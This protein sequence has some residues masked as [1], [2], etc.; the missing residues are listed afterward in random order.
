MVAVVGLSFIGGI[1]AEP[2]SL[3]GHQAA[4]ADSLPARERPSADRLIVPR[5]TPLVD[6]RDDYDVQHYVLDLWLDLDNQVIGG[7]VTVQSLVVAA[8]L[9]TMVLD[10]LDNM[11]VD[12]V[13]IG[14]A[15]L[16]FT[17]QGD[18]VRIALDRAYLQGEEISPVVFYHGH[19]SYT[20]WATFRFSTHGFPGV[21]LVFSISWPDNSRGWWPCKDVLYDKAT[22]EVR[23]TVPVDQ[24]DMVV[25]SIGRLISVVQNPDTTRTYTWRESYPITTYNISFSTTNFDT[26]QDR[27]VGLDGDTLSVVHFV[28]PEDRER[29]RESFSN[30]VN[31]MEVYAG[32]YGEYPFMGEKYGMAEV[33]LSGAMEHQTMTSYGKMLITGGHTYDTIV[34]HELSHQW[35]GD[36]ITIGTWP[37]IWLS[38]GFATYSE[39]LYEESLY[40]LQGYLDYMESLDTHDFNDTVYDP[41]NLLS[42]TVYN[43]GAW[44][45]HM[46]RHVMGDSLLFETLSDYAADTTFRYGNAV[47]ADFISACEDHYGGDLDWFFTPWLNTV[48]RPYYYMDWSASGQDSLYEADVQLDQTQPGD[49]LYTMPIDLV[50]HTSSGEST[51]TVRDSLRSQAFHFSLPEEPLD[52]A[53][54]PDNWVLKVVQA[55][56]RI[57]T[58][59][60]PHG[61]VGEVYAFQIRAEG[62]VY[63]LTWTI[64]SGTLPDS[65]LM[66]TSLGLISGVPREAGNF[67]LTVEVHDAFSPPHADTS[68]FTLV[69][70]PS[71]GIGGG[72]VPNLDLPRAYGLFQNYPNPFNPSTVIPFDVPEHSEGPLCLAIYDLR[73]RRVRTLVRGDIAPG[74][75]TV[76]WNGRDNRGGRVPSGVYIY[77]LRTSGFT[78]TRRMLLVQ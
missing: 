27:Y 77:R 12:S 2:I 29:A 61:T 63:P 67:P 48:G 69:V 14:G 33:Q 41:D 43:K 38:E 46:L 20:G 56:L 59:S 10:L 60:L 36:M 72:G 55:P 30:T 74:R 3:R 51:F 8:T 50:F 21:P 15:P 42:S 57:T 34:A 66:D 39:A 6:R 19:P 22:A 68:S 64:L 65:M 18:Q 58:D 4:A 52:V 7:G 75:H 28:F 16:D 47:T 9:D 37:D 35:F 13:K 26:L 5:P 76:Y 45:L 71:A 31:M 25:A 32:L 54:D 53:L 73:G 62:G 23:M 78:A 1:P 40:G 44:V 49:A 11:T 70:E 24:Y 17:H